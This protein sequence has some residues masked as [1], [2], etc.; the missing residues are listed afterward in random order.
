MKICVLLE[1]VIVSW[2]LIS[3]G[4]HEGSWT[5]IS[6][7]KVNAFWFAHTLQTSLLF[8]S[9]HDIIV[10]KELTEVSIIIL[11]TNFDTNRKP[12]VVLL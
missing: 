7:I 11:N 1:A 12:S 9:I 2:K 4:V 6:D 5:T 3:I 10:M 8:G